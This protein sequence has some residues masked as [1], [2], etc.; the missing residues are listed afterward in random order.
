MV[1]IY[2]VDLCNKKSF[3]YI[4]LFLIKMGLRVSLGTSRLLNLYVQKNNTCN[5]LGIHAVPSQYSEIHIL[6]LLNQLPVPQN[7]N[8]WIQE[9]DK[10]KKDKVY[11]VKLKR[12]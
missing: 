5:Y 12:L 4:A 8:V 2:D 3:T 7:C 11:P 10:P 1:V 9:N 6:A